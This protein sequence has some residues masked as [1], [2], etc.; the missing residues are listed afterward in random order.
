M[1]DLQGKIIV[2]LVALIAVTLITAL[3]C[4][5]VYLH[6]LPVKETMEQART[7]MQ[8]IDATTAAAR[9]TMTKLNA[10]VASAGPALGVL[11][12]LGSRRLE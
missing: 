8:N 9:E 5:V 2:A 10:A 1:S 7:T 12:A 4:A 6:S 3:I 11:G